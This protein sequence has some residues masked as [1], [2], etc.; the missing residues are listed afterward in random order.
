MGQT[1]PQPRLVLDYRAIEATSVELAVSDPTAWRGLPLRLLQNLP[2]GELSV[3]PM[4]EDLVM[5]MVSG[6]TWLEGSLQRPFAGRAIGPGQLFCIPRGAPSNW[7]WTDACQV[8]QLP[9]A[10]ARLAEQLGALAEIDVARVELV[11]SVAV[12]DPLLNQLALALL[13]ELRAEHPAGRL[14]IESLSQSILMHLLRRHAVRHSEP[15]APAGLPAPAVRMV[16]DYVGDNLAEDLGLREL[17]TLAG[18]SPYHFA[19]L[20][21]RA[22][23]RTPHAYVRERRLEAAKDL[24]LKGELAVGAV[25]A[26]TGFADQSHLSRE[27]RRH[28]GLTP[29][30]LRRVQT[31]GGEEAGR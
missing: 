4:D 29:G 13:A 2:Q 30:A 24:L 10:P 21:R 9:L 28:Y 25:A 20:F 1:E 12:E 31:R 8:V 3:P 22:V 5:L 19:R 11:P 27:F 16:R 14:Y 18:M 23:G 17:A 15:R 26:L 6:E 7:R